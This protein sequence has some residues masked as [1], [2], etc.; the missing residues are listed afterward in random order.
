MSDS[1]HLML[2]ENVEVHHPHIY[3][4]DIAKLSCSN[5]KI[6]NKIRVLPVANLEPD[7]PG[8]Y[9]MS[10]MDLVKEIQKKEPDLDINTIGEPTFII[11]YQNKPGPN[12]IL[13]WLKV[14]FV[15]FATFFGA[16]FSI[17]TFNNDV[18]VPGLLN[19]V[20][21]QVTGQASSGF[22]ILEISYSIGIGIGVLFFF[23]HFSHLKLTSDPTPMQVQMRK[24]EEDVN[25]TI[26]EQVDRQR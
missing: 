18:D 1:L 24:Y 26:M 6:L 8:R 16:A 19:K 11:T 21:T 23:N 4:Q 9:V 25:T 5:P 17:M 14:I 15:C 20:H 13:R 7:K 10:V 3:L 2:E 22:S 12:L